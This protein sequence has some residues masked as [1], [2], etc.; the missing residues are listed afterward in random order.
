MLYGTSYLQVAVMVETLV[1]EEGVTVVEAVGVTV[2]EAVV[3][4]VAVADVTEVLS[5]IWLDARSTSFCPL[6]AASQS[7]Q[8]IQAVYNNQVNNVCCPFHHSIL[9]TVVTML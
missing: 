8:L 3:V 7:I 6:C 1:K 5:I 9:A 2:V 4:A